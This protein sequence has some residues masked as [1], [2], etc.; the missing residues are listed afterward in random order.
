MKYRIKSYLEQYAVYY[1]FPFFTM[2][3]RIT[4]MLQEKCWYGWRTINKNTDKQKIEKQ[5]NELTHIF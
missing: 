4:Y 1:S 2:D 5:F 3:K